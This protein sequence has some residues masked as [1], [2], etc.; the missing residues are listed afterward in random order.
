V[1]SDVAEP[2]AIA[3]FKARLAEGV[4]AFIPF[5]EPRAAPKSPARIPL[6]ALF[7]H[8]FLFLST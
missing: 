4:T 1:P 2:D 5:E 8:I 6:K 3:G 7:L